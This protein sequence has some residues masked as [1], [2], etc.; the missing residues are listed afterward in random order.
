[1]TV[2]NWIPREGEG[3]ISARV[4]KELADF[5]DDI[6]KNFECNRTDAIC[7]ILKYAHDCN[8]TYKGIKWYAKEGKLPADLL[9][10]FMD[11]LAGMSRPMIKDSR[12]MKTEK[13]R[14]K[15]SI[16]NSTSP[17]MLDAIVKYG[18]NAGRTVKAYQPT[19]NG[20]PDKIANR[21]T[22]EDGF[23]LGGTPKPAT[24]L[25][26]ENN[27]ESVMPAGELTIAKSRGERVQK[28]KRKKDKSIMSAVG[29]R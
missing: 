4:P 8:E 2:E 28:R 12:R 11:K 24:T 7:M 15:Q 9:G 17:A 21:T 25:D 19:D 6:A 16:E 13:E 10:M 5:V 18:P 3:H 14:L 22:A 29:C 20:Q 23:R 1:M 27:I 26:D